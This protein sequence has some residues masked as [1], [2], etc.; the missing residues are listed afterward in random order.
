MTKLNEMSLRAAPMMMLG[1]E[2]LL[3]VAGGHGHHH[4]HDHDGGS[5]SQSNSIG[6]ITINAP[7]N[8]GTITIVIEQGNSSGGHGHC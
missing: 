6:D 1:D 4:H 2:E 8:S 7:N 5:T 3:A